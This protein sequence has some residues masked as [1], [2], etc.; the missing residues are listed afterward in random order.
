MSFAGCLLAPVAVEML[1]RMG[2]KCLPFRRLIEHWPQYGPALGAA[3]A[4]AIKESA[5]AVARQ[6]SLVITLETPSTL[7]NGGCLRA[8]AGAQ[9]AAF[10]MLDT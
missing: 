3:L 2:D 8:P 6:C 10:T 9:P 7:F 5:D 4:A 1:G